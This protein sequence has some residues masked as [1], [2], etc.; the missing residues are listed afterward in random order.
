MYMI[1]LAE[2]APHVLHLGLTV[3]VRSARCKVL[4]FKTEDVVEEVLLMVVF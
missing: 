2:L 1:A 3:E 4:F